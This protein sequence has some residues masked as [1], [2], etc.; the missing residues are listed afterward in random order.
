MRHCIDEKDKLLDCAKKNTYTQRQ[1]QTHVPVCMSQANCLF[2]A[3]VTATVCV[4]VC[5]CVYR[6]QYVRYVNFVSF[7]LSPFNTYLQ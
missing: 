4:C 1:T 5:V 6:T 3:T 7:H 2:T